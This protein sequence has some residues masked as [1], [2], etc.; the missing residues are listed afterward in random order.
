MNPA[1]LALSL[2]ALALAPG[3]ATAQTYSDD[4]DRPNSTDM[5]PDWI[6]DYGDLQILDN[7][8]AGIGT[9]SLMVHATASGDYRDAVA[10][11]DMLAPV[12][13]QLRYVAIVL[14]D[15]GARNLFT[16]L[17]DNDS[18]GSYD[19][20]WFYSADQSQGWAPAITTTTPIAGPCRMIQYV[21]NDGDTMNVDL[22][23]NFDG[24]VDQHYEASG[25]LAFASQLGTG[26]GI[27]TFGTSEF[28]D[29]TVT[30]GAQGIAADVSDVSAFAGGTQTIVVDPGDTFAGLPYL[31][32]GSVSG[33]SP[34]LP[35][36][37]FVLPLIVD[38]YMFH[39][40]LSPNQ[41]PLAGSLGLLSAAGDS[42]A[43]FTVPPQFPPI[44]VGTTFY[45]AYV[46]LEAT[47]TLLRVV[48]ASD[49]V[50]ALIVP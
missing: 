40:L 47:P 8:G 21:T 45:H 33:T 41:P 2:A 25:I 14:G 13:G 18:N 34:G 10:Q 30:F 5:G 1:V 35:L 38:Q 44:W 27:G 16:K 36:D 24:V 31:L 22:D 50:S 37:G 12:A 11:I 46:V 23:E 28:D 9:N 19:R 15:G 17:Q 42:S 49:F 7:R 29:W 43:T 3:A 6:E 20:I 4:F 26:L 48:Y 39:T 32:L